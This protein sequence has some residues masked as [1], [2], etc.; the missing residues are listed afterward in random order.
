MPR[1]RVHHGK[2]YVHIPLE[3]ETDGSD[4]PPHIEESRE[5][6]PG[7]KLPKGA[8][9]TEEPSLE[10]T[11]TRSGDM[12]GGWVQVSIDMPREKWLENMKT[13]EDD[14]NVIARAMYTD[15]LSR[16]EINNMI[17]VLRR[18]RDAAYGADE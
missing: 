11:W 4:T 2:L 10:V 13:L 9:V 14:P 3:Q 16:Q 12:L 6:I 17:K 15:S 8:Y 18:A 1:E 5:F 7:E